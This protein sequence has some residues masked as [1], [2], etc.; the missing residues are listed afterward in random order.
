MLKLL[1]VAIG[2]SFLFACNNKPAESTP[3]ATTDSS[4]AVKETKTPQSEFADAKYTD[5]GKQSLMKFSSGDIDGWMN[6]FAD[7]AIYRWSAGDS[8]VGKA[9]ISQYWKERRGKVIDSLQFMN[10]IWLPIKVNR[11]QKGP[12]AVG[13]WLLSWHEVHVRYKN[14]KKLVFWVH[15]DYHY[16]AS[17]KIDVAIQYIDRAPINKALGVK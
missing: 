16:D 14:G 7:N 8:L 5:L 4:S 12:D 10:D 11:P 1:S 17:D 6:D 13:N 3:A 9:A 2:C 15:T